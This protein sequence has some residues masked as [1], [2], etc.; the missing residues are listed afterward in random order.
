MV[1]VLAH[2]LATI[3]RDILGQPADPDRCAAAGLKIHALSDYRHEK[4][5][6]TGMLVVNYSGLT[7][8]TLEKLEQILQKGI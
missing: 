6:D 8:E 4:Q 1:A 7:D 3:Q 2:G 5:Q